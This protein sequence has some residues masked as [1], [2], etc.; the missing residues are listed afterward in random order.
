MSAPR[1][2]VA[3]AVPSPSEDPLGWAVTSRETGKVVMWQNPNLPA[4]LSTVGAVLTGVSPRGSGMQRGAAV[5]TLL[6]ST[7]WGVDELARGV[8]PFR[9]A[10]GAGG[11]T[12]VVAATVVALRR[13]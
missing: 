8:N 3:P 6:V 5:G 11:L 10:L 7:W 9:K 1:T 13:R 2:L 12:A 4:V